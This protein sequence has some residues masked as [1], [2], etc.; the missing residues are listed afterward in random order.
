MM[1]IGVLSFTITPIS[2]FSGAFVSEVYTVMLAQGYFLQDLH[3]LQRFYHNIDHW[4]IKLYHHTNF[5][6]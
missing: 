4:G 1:I 5:H 6:T 2:T 3:G